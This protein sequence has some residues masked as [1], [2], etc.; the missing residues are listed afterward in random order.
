MEWWRFLAGCIWIVENDFS[1]WT[2]YGGQRL[3][4]RLLCKFA[5]SV[6]SCIH[7]GWTERDFLWVQGYLPPVVGLDCHWFSDESELWHVIFEW[8]VLALQAVQ[9]PD[10]HFANEIYCA[11]LVV[12]IWY[13]C[14]DSLMWK[15]R[16]DQC[17]AVVDRVSDWQQHQY[18]SKWI[19][20]M[21]WVSNTLETSVYQIQVTCHMW[22]G[23]C[24][25][26]GHSIAWMWTRLGLVS[27]FGFKRLGLLVFL[28]SRLP[29][30]Q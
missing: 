16:S 24:H 9:L 27:W 7:M 6:T 13:C 18:G 10:Y 28:V 26:L 12:V 15:S 2:D 8:W 23:L 30:H 3:A 14:V 29:V 20:F 11:W 4:Q 5:N 19:R 25:G 1:R 21:R 22:Q 17:F